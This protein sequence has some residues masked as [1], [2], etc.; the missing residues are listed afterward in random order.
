MTKKHRVLIHLGMKLKGVPISQTAQF[1]CT[2]PESDLFGQSAS[3]SSK[4]M[5]HGAEFLARWKH[6]LT[7]F[8]LS[9]TY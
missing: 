3:S 8:S 9:P 4:N 2:S 1:Y 6:C 5:T 7:A